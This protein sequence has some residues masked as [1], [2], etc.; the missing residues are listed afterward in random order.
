MLQNPYSISTGFL[1]TE[2]Q[3]KSDLILKLLGIFPCGNPDG[4]YNSEALSC[5][6]LLNEEWFNKKWEYPG[7]P[8]YGGILVDCAS[9]EQNLIN[10]T[11]SCS[12]TDDEQNCLNKCQNDRNNG[13]PSVSTCAQKQKEKELDQQKLK[14]LNA[15]CEKYY[16]KQ[17]QYQ[18]P[19]AR[20]T[21]RVGNPYYR[22]RRI[23]PEDFP[24]RW[25]ESPRWRSPSE[26]Q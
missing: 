4:S 10:C 3:D 7:D 12:D 2:T 26:S 5:C 16:G 23:F 11:Q 18:D 20:P 13:I 21:E 24:Y 19:F 17:N 15:N 22:L 8:N 1:Q 14:E 6:Y 25:R 9:A